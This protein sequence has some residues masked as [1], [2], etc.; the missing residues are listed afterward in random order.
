M[1]RHEMKKPQQRFRIAQPIRFLRL[2]RLLQEDQSIHHRKI[3]AR[4]PRSPALEL[5][6]QRRP[7]RG[8]LLQQLLADA[9]HAAH[10]A[11]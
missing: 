3:V 4:D 6:V 8:N 11:K 10:V 9:V 7:G 1:L 2:L 5:P